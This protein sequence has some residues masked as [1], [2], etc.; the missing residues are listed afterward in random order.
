MVR[1][2]LPL[3]ELV[4]KVTYNATNPM[5]EF[6][7]DSGWWIAPCLQDI[8]SRLNDDAFSNEAWAAFFSGQVD[9]LL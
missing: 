8:L 5:D 3:G 4:A 9:L 6:D 7:E 2:L 1:S